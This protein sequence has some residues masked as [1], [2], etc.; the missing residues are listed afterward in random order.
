VGVGEVLRAGADEVDVGAFFEDEAGG[1][2]GVTQA[3]NTG[4]AAGFHAAAVHEQGIELDP[5]VGGEKA[6]AT[7][8][9][10]GIV[11][12]DGDSCFDGI[13]SGSAAR[14]ECIASLEG[15]AYS[16]LVGGGGIGGDSPSAAVDEKRGS[17]E[18]GSSHRD[19]VDDLRGGVEIAGN[20]E[21]RGSNLVKVSKSEGSEWRGKCLKEWA[22]E[23]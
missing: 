22:E 10:G 20:F 2:D 23:E 17:V 13:E 12:E 18:K 4:H 19:I 16:G 8:I 6:A 21:I 9:E 5:A 11:F 1:L 14:E 7:G 3:F 15:A